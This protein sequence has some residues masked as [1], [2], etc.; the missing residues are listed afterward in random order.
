MKLAKMTQNIIAVDVTSFY[1]VKNKQYQIISKND[2]RETPKFK[3]G[4]VMGEIEGIRY[5]NVDVHKDI[6]LKL[7][8]ILIK[9]NPHK[10]QY[11]KELDIQQ[12]SDTVEESSTLLDSSDKSSGQD[13]FIERSS[14]INIS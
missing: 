13:F 2:K 4:S 14:T 9:D 7:T 10:Y 3:F 1:N 6:G 12:V 5:C 11:L 8:K